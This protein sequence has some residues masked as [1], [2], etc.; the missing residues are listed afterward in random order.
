MTEVVLPPGE[1]YLEDTDSR[2]LPGVRVEKTFDGTQ[3]VIEGVSNLVIRAEQPLKTLLLAASTYSDV[4]VFRNCRRI[5][6]EGLVLGHG[7]RSGHCVG[8]VVEMENCEDMALDQCELFGSGAH[9]MV[10]LRTRRVRVS[11]T[12]IRDCTY[13]LLEADASGDL[14]FED[15]RFENNRQY[16]MVTLN[17][18]YGKTAPHP[19]RASFPPLEFVRCSFTGNRVGGPGAGF[20]QPFF[21]IGRRGTIRLV[22]CRLEQ[23]Y[24]AW[25]RSRRGKLHVE[26]CEIAKGQWDRT[27]PPLVGPWLRARWQRIHDMLFP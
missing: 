23:N 7:E 26:E 21:E 4:L 12:L 6:L 19:K 8:D 20:P 1:C 22:E 15:C 3:W 18:E 17:M 27:R 10:L 9:G 14:R 13:G 16:T 2:L 25:F 11:R 5:R 24:A